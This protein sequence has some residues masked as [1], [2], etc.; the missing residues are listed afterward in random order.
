MSR[1]IFLSLCLVMSLFFGRSAFAEY[2]EITSNMAV[3]FLK[4]PLPNMVF[5]DVRTSREYE[6][7][8][9]KG[10][11]LLDIYRLEFEGELKKLD[12]NVPYV[13]YCL[14]G[15]RSQKAYNKMK[16]LGF[17]NVFIMPS[18]I[19]DWKDKKLPLVSGPSPNGVD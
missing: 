14:A 13:V 17:S 7:G 12:R 3:E 1:Y 11:Q 15:I 9:I 4:N 5:L 19:Y 8:H 2:F 10:A 6:E 16:K 18:G